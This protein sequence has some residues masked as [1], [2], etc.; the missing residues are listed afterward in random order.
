MPNTFGSISVYDRSM[1]GPVDEDSGLPTLLL[2]NKFH[3]SAGY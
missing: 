1:V 3:F 2:K